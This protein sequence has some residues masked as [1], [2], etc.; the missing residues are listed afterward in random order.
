LPILLI[1]E[2]LACL[3]DSVPVVLYLLGDSCFKAINVNGDLVSITRSEV[4]GLFH[5]M[6]DLAVTPYSLMRNPLK[7]LDRLIIACGNRRILIL[8]ALP[9]FFLMTCCDNLAHCANISRH[10]ETQVEAGKEFMQDLEDLNNQLAARLNSR[11]AQFLFTGDILS[12]KNHCSIGDLAG[13]LYTCW[14]SDPVHGDKSAYMKIAVGLM[15][16][17]DH[18]P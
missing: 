2:H 1:L 15:D 8:G 17:L 9:R 18:Q 16:F 7:E 11:N 14:R 4:D 6:G 5:V 12:G 10:D 13:C 3:P